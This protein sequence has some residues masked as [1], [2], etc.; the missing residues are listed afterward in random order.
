[1]YAKLIG[2]QIIKIIY[3]FGIYTRNLFHLKIT[4]QFG[5]HMQ[6]AQVQLD[7]KREI[8]VTPSIDNEATF[9]LLQVT[10]QP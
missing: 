9:S 6:V 8:D 4:Y 1:M 3:Q 10:N 7:P 2:D 5:I